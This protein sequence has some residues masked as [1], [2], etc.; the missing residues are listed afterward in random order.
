MTNG[1]V[2]CFNDSKGFGFI[3]PEDQSKDV[4]IHH[5]NIAGGDEFKSLNE[6][7]KVTF[8]TAEGQKGIEARNV[9]V[10]E[11]APADYQS[12]RPPRPPRERSFRPRYDKY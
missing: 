5:S 3:T 2:K 8:D 10:T 6:G 12:S 9:V 1:T 11:K 4:F 7:D